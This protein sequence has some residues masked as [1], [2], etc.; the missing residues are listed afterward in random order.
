MTHH[1]PHHTLKNGETNEDCCATMIPDQ[2]SQKT[3]SIDKPTPKKNPT[4]TLQFIAIILVLTVVL[5]VLGMALFT[6]TVNAKINM[7]IEQSAPQSGSLTLIVPSDCSQCGELS[8]ERQT[9]T[10]LNVV[11]NDEVRIDATSDEAQQLITSKKISKLPAM[12]FVAD[13]K[14][15]EDIIKSAQESGANK[16]GETELVWETKSAPYLNVANNE[17]AGLVHITYITDSN[18]ENCY[19]VVSTQRGALGRFGLGISSE[20]IIDISSEKGAELLKTYAI[21]QVPTLILSSEAGVYETLMQVWPQVGTQEAD[22]SYVFR[23]LEA[24]NGVYKNLTTGKII[25]PEIE[26]K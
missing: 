19:D 2:Q 4:Q 1:T 16:L 18:C 22:G 12:I 26:K 17:I 14:I 25:N 8:Q 13:K 10:N 11:I 5:N 20:D 15:R 23:E 9:F 6:F 7:A 21:T 24:I 3:E